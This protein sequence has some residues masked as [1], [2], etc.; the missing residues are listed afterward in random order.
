MPIIIS[1]DHASFFDL[2][3][4]WKIRNR[5]STT[6]QTILFRQ[7]D[8]PLVHFQVL[9]HDTGSLHHA[10]SRV[11]RDIARDTDRFRDQLIK[12]YSSFSRSFTTL[13]TSFARCESATKLRGLG[14]LARRSK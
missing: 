1:I 14:R 3:P 10:E 12:D 8:A 6:E 2:L 5:F 4:I 7:D 11:V 13:S 9:K